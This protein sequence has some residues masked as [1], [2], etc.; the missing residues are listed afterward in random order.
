MWDIG[1]D[2]D[3]KDRR[4]RFFLLLYQL[5]YKPPCEDLVGLEPTTTR[6]H[7]V[8]STA[9]VAAPQAGLEPAMTFVVGLGSR[10]LIR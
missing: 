7:I 3:D 10:C 6:L 8:V 4:D 5:S 1:K 9:F 2:C